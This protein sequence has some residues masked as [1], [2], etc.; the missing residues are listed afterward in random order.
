MHY[1]PVRVARNI[2][3][4]MAKEYL[5]MADVDDRT[6]PMFMHALS[7]KGLVLHLNT[8]RTIMFLRDYALQ[9]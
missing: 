5:V 9:V 6:I 2:K 8:R 7:R 4:A 3:T 1:A